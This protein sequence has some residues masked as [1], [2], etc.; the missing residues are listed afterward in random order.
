[1]HGDDYYLVAGM[2]DSLDM[3]G[4][5]WNIVDMVYAKDKSHRIMDMT[6]NPRVGDTVILGKNA[7]GAY[8]V[9][10]HTKKE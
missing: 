10:I 1:M 8:T 9:L 4:N 2:R 3:A 6:G 5:L 7:T